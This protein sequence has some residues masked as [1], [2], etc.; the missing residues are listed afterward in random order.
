MSSGTSKSVNRVS[1][2]EQFAEWLLMTPSARGEAA[3]P[4]TQKG[5]AE[6]LGVS[7]ATLSV[8]KKDEKFQ[9]MV[10]R[11]VRANFGAERLGRIIDALFDVA[12][13]GSGQAQVS[14]AK[15][16]LTWHGAQVEAPVAEDLEHLSNDELRALA[17]RV[18]TEVV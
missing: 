3:L 5:L 1:L 17:Q 8:W 12:T 18:L 2:M 7:E 14:A 10:S 15:T 4:S 9:R 6:L 13:E 11:H 16:L